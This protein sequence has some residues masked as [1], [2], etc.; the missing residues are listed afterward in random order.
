MFGSIHINHHSQSRHNQTFDPYL[1]KKGHNTSNTSFYI[2]LKDAGFYMFCPSQPDWEDLSDVDF[3]WFS[4]VFGM[5][6]K[7]HRTQHIGI[8][9]EPSVPSLQFLSWVENHKDHCSLPLSP[10]FCKCFFTDGQKRVIAP[11][12]SLSAVCLQMIMVGHMWDILTS[13]P[14]LNMLKLPVASDITRYQR[15]ILPV[16]AI[17]FEVQP[18]HGV[19][20]GSHRFQRPLCSGPMR[21]HQHHSMEY[22]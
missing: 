12:P 15:R 2:W 21:R 19:C 1:S 22:Y 5:P 11:W 20:H 14:G 7:N 3:P 9:D 6:L 13:K 16:T 18:N 8:W 4:I 17:S 10:P